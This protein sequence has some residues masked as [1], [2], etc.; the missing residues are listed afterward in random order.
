MSNLLPMSQAPKQAD[1]TL[2]SITELPQGGYPVVYVDRENSQLCA[3][4][5]QASL[6]EDEIPAFRPIGFY[7]LEEDVVY[8]DQS[9]TSGC[10]G[11]MGDDI[12]AHEQIEEI[13]APDEWAY[14]VEQYHPDIDSL[15][16][17]HSLGY[18]E[19]RRM[20]ATGR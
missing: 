5:A 16:G 1:G 7:V 8:C 12:I 19:V 14:P 17:Q 13:V 2:S 20:H 15:R 10:L 3:V 6:S 4:C 18:T 9:G 11:F